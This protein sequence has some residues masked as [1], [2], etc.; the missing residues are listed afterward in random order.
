MIGV[1]WRAPVAGFVVQPEM[2]KQA[3]ANSTASINLAPGMA[4]CS[5]APQYFD[6]SAGKGM[7]VSPDF[8]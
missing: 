6:D 2:P 3:A 1:I 5:D 7:K 8:P 4:A